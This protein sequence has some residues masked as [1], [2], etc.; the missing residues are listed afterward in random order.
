MSQ[1][2]WTVR[3]PPGTREPFTVFVNGVRQA[4]GTD[5]V[6]T[7][8][9]L[10]FTRELHRETRLSFWRWFIGAFGIGTY[11]RNDQVDVAW[12][13]EGAPR[14]AHALEI[15]PPTGASPSAR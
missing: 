5:Y 11:G 10:R 9:E 14:V 2:H 8:G 13:V 6:V 3:L 12:H 7:G 15:T 4:E 1:D